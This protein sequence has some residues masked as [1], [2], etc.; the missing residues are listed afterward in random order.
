M[1]IKEACSNSNEQIERS[2]QRLDALAQLLDGVDREQLARVFQPLGSLP[3]D[4][5]GRETL[6]DQAEQWE[7]S[8]SSLTT[9]CSAFTPCDALSLEQVRQAADQASAVVSRLPDP[10]PAEGEALLPVLGSPAIAGMAQA[11]LDALPAD[12]ESE[13]VVARRFNRPPEA[14][15]DMEAIQA[16]VAALSQWKLGT[17]VMPAEQ[18][19]REELRQRL[20]QATQTA[21]RLAVVLE[22]S[23]T[24]L[25]LLEFSPA[26]LKAILPL[27]EHLS[28]QPE[29]VLRQR[30]APIWT[31]NPEQARALV[32]EHTALQQ[33]RTQLNLDQAAPQQPEQ[34]NI[35]DALEQPRCSR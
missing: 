29:W 12:S 15:P 35:A 17:L 30:S 9:A 14:L 8:L 25:D 22:T 21:D 3:A 26:S 32:Q 5:I 18:Q 13:A 28:A 34:L 24:G 1:E 16:L 6:L 33:L 19:A 20:R 10:L 27:A 4:A 11:L 2:A 31:A 7:A 23:C